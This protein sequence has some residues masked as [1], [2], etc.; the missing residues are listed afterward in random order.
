M[1][2]IGCVNSQRFEE[3]VIAI[4]FILFGVFLFYGSNSVRSLFRFK[5]VCK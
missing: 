4:D 1:L 2:D 3:A 5:E